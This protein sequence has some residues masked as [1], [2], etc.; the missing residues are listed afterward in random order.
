VVDWSLRSEKYLEL[1]LFGLSRKA[2]KMED[3]DRIS[4]EKPEPD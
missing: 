3:T 4:N 2:L 1:F